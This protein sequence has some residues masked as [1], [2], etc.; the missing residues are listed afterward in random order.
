[1]PS[2]GQ[3]LAGLKTIANSWTALAVVWHVFFGAIIIAVILGKLTMHD[4][5]LQLIDSDPKDPFDLCGQVEFWM[6]ET[7]MVLDKSCLI[8]IPGGMRHAPLRFLRI[9]RPIFH[10]SS[11]TEPAW[12]PQKA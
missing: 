6:E 1:M 11:V 9:D 3:I 4:A 5:D 7:R 10:F 2:P 8:Y 12:T